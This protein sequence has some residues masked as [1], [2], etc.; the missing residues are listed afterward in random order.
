MTGP[1]D[2]E[3]PG[4]GRP[5]P[6]DALLRPVIQ[7]LPVPE[8]SFERIRRTAARR[9]RAKAAAGGGLVA[10]L[11]A[12]SLLLGGAFTAPGP[13]VV[14]TPPVASSGLTPS[15]SEP[16]RTAPPSPSTPVPSSS[17]SGGAGGSRPTGTGGAA[18]SA[19]PGGPSATSTSGAVAATPMCATSQL[20]AK[21]GG[22][23]A[24]AGNVYRYLVLTNH[25]G[26][27]CHVTGFPG[28]SLLSADGTQ[29][30][31]PAT[32]QSIA[33]APVVLR[34]GESAS[35]TVHTANRQTSSSTECLP[36]SAELRIYPPGNRDPLVFP[37]Q[38]TNCD[39]LFSVTP[40]TAGSTGNPPS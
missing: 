35:D 17:A 34:P 3:E 32:E 26:T 9:R 14:V 16:G 22:G 39:N 20:T 31:A 15:P 6:L 25:S 11:V 2:D 33:H 38:V 12:G 23:D 30:G 36:S 28:L 19:A 5:D 7:F 4:G 40:F 18:G 24:G 21:L 37:G 13:T 27:T 8:G 29:I 1:T 10:V